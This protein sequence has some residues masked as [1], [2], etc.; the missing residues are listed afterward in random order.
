MNQFKC[1]LFNFIGKQ[2][3]RT[4]VS[5]NRLY[6]VRN[7][8]CLSLEESSDISYFLFL[9]KHMLPIIVSVK[10]REIGYMALEM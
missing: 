6:N 5:P 3:L 1:Y 8:Y 10:C 7:C 9:E 4:I 2:I